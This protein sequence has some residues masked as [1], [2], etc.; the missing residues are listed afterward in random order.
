MIV[1]KKCR[2]R[3]IDLMGQ[4][5]NAYWLLGAAKQFYDSLG[6]TKE[7]S[8]A[9]HEDMTSGDYTHLV[10]VFEMNFGHFVKLEADD[11]LLEEVSKEIDRLNELRKEE[12]GIARPLGTVEYDEYH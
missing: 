2:E 4:E 7:E 12:C 11:E 10:A 9:L 3:I 8:D 5:G 6:K 1:R